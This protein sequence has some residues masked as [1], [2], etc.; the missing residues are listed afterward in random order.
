MAAYAILA[1]CGLPSE[2]TP[3]IVPLLLL[4]GVE[5][6][7]GITSDV[8]V[9]ELENIGDADDLNVRRRIV[10]EDRIMLE[11]SG[12]G[13]TVPGKPDSMELVVEVDIVVGLRLRDALSNTPSAV[14]AMNEIVAGSGAVF[15]SDTVEDTG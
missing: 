2:T 7:N 13:R 8:I 4:K 11:V 9:F 1:V 3:G 5:V 6:G 12:S 10:L 14:N 15:A